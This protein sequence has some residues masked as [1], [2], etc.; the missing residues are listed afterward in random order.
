[1]KN[2]L[3]F[4][5]MTVIAHHAVAGPTIKDATV[6]QTNNNETF[7]LIHAEGEDID[8]N[9]LKFAT[10][11]YAQLAFVE[12]PEPIPLAIKRQLPPISG[13]TFKVNL[14][15]LIKEFKED[16]PVDFLL[17]FSNGEKMRIQA[18]YTAIEN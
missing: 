6:Y 12:T 17:T 4:L 3:I 2:L 15:E 1:M 16:V 9:Y 11:S 5:I 10:T 7:A 14:K 8:N 18:T 13:M